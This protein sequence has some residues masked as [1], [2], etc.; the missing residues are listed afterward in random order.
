MVSSKRSKKKNYSFL[1]WQ[2]RY[3]RW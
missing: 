2:C 1:S 3:I